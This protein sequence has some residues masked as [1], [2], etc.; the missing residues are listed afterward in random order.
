[1]RTAVRALISVLT[2]L[3]ILGIMFVCVPRFLL[4][5]PAPPRHR[6]QECDAKVVIPAV[7]KAFAADLPSDLREIRAG[8]TPAVEGY[9]HFVIRFTAD[10]VS[11][12]RFLKSFGKREYESPY[13]P[14]VD[15]RGIAPLAPNV[16]KWF[17][18]PITKGRKIIAG[19]VGKGVRATGRVYVD[20]TNNMNFIVYI[21][22][23]IKFDAAGGSRR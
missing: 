8:K 18:T 17:T 20:T 15:S 23:H 14:E 2:T 16:R 11:T 13:R 19:S 7:E 21:E 3:L 6:L 22:A 9:V 12:E 10:P 4:P 5:R 1:M